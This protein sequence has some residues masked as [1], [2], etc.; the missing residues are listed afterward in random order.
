M[1]RLI[2]EGFG[3][4]KQMQDWLDWYSNSGEQDFATAQ[5]F[6]E[7]ENE[8]SGA[9]YRGQEKVGEDIV[10]Q[11]RVH[12]HAGDDEEDPIQEGN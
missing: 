5:E 4:T 7:E 12:R 8:I 10:V 1:A 9:D 3:S 11:F 6:R 2:I